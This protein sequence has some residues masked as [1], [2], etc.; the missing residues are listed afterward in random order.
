M[1]LLQMWLRDMRNKRLQQVPRVVCKSGLHMSVQ[2]SE[3]HYCEPR[4]NHGPWTHVEI[5]YPSQI[6]PELAPYNEDGYGDI[7]AY[8]PI[9]LVEQIIEDNGGFADK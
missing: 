7:Y 2:A 5:G 4:D 8:V 9:E 6:L 3:M 1:S